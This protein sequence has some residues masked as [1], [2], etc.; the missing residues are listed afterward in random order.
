MKLVGNKLK[1][2]RKKDVETWVE[3]FRDIL[4]DIPGET[5]IPEFAINT[6]DAR[7]ISQRPY[8]T[9]LGLR[10]GIEEE[11]DWLLDKGDQGI[12]NSYCM[13]AKWKD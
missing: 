4:T 2:Y 8:M 9:A 12:P 6:G 13:E 1:D 11:L 5:S 3:E 7:P 10:E